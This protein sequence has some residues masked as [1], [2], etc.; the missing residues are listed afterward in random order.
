MAEEDG[1]ESATGRRKKRNAKA[2]KM[3]K[4]IRAPPPAPSIAKAPVP[5]ASTPTQSASS[6]T[7]SAPAPPAPTPAP[8]RAYKIAEDGSSNLEDLFG[9]GSDQLRELNEQFLPLPREDLVTGKE[10]V[11]DDTDKVFKLPDLSEFMQETGGKN[12]RQLLE[13]RK[14]AGGAEVEAER[15]DRRNR[16]EYLRVL[17]LNPFADADESMFLDEYDIIQSIFGTGSLLKIPIPYLQT[18]HGILLIVI[19]LGGYIYAPGNPLTEF[20]PE[21][22]EAFR[23]GLTITYAI[24]TVLAVKSFFIAREKNLPGLFWGAKSFI[25][26]GIAYYELSQVKDPK[27]LQTYRGPKPEDRKAKR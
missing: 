18:G 16:D 1:E 22:R 19:V 5:F 24:N 6:F 26:G 12:E 23:T 11:T 21:I 20:P 9:L 10:V 15:V 7:P 14:A 25:L 27:S 2:K 4:E 3:G 8:V 17:Q 13:E